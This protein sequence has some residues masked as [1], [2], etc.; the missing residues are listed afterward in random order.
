[1]ETP[2]LPENLHP[3]AAPPQTPNATIGEQSRRRLNL[4]IIL[5][6]V[7]PNNYYTSDQLTLRYTKKI[8]QR[9]ALNIGG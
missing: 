5:E 9:F 1:M 2:A 8:L 3:H 6:V 7:S 4:G